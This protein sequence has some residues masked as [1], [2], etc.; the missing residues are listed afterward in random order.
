MVCP[1][2]MHGICHAQT[3]GHSLVLHCYSGHPACCEHMH[4]HIQNRPLPGQP[5]H[6]EGL[7]NMRPT[8]ALQVEAEEVDELTTTYDVSMVP[9]FVLL[10]KVGHA[11]MHASKAGMQPCRHACRCA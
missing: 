1:L 8:L 2:V 3:H 6:V 11:F 5:M 10:L 7:G 9:C 4:M